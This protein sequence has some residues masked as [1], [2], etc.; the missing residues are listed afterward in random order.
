MR[1]QG[2]EFS[3]RADVTRRLEVTANYSYLDAVNRSSDPTL[4]VAYTPEHSANLSANWQVGDALG[5]FATANYVGH[6]YLN[7]SPN[8]R[9]TVARDGYATVDTSVSYRFPRLTLR[10][11]LLNLFDVRQDRLTSIDYNEDGRRAFVSA[12]ARF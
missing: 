8:P 5:W 1:T 3:L 11:G 4:P 12:A 10:A 6:Q 2:I 9:Y 7:V